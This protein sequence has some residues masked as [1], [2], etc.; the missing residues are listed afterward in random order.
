MRPLDVTQKVGTALPNQFTNT[1]PANNPVTIVNDMTNFG[2]EFVWHCHILGHEENDMMRAVSFVVAPDAADHAAAAV[3]G[4]NISITWADNSINETGF[5]V[6]RSLKDPATQ[7]YGAWTDLPL[8]SA[9]QGGAT[10]QEHVTVRQNVTHYTDT[11]AQKNH[12]YKYRVV[13]NN[14]VGYT[15][16]FAA[17][18]VGYSWQS[19]DAAPAETADITKP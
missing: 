4:Q 19:G 11:T 6:Q 16:Q 12:T 5:T 14:V 10:A 13:A 3:A 2:A 8:P 17:P 1:D 18:A 7:L 9:A 15:R